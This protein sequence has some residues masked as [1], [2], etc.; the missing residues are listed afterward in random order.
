MGAEMRPVLAS[1]LVLLALPAAASAQTPLP[2]L[3]YAAPVASISA[4]PR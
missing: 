3:E 2:P 4:A 1:I